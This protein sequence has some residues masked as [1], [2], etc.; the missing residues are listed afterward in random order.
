MK[1]LIISALLLICSNSVFAQ[2]PAKRLEPKPENKTITAE[3]FETINIGYTISTKSA[4]WDADNLDL[5]IFNLGVNGF[6]KFENS[7]ILG[8]LIDFQWYIPGE[9]DSFTAATIAP[10]FG[11]HIG[12]FD[13]FQVIAY[14][15]I[16]PATISIDGE[17]ELSVHYGMHLGIG[18]NIVMIEL[19]NNGIGGIESTSVGLKIKI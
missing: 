13:G 11:A 12:N 17:R 15:H 4:M 16:G 10:A 8:G 7:I 2:S 3:Y 1:T 9:G 6:F 5:N 18:F 14:G 19:S